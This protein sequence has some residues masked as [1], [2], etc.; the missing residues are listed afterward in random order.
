MYNV[1]YFSVNFQC[2]DFL[3]VC[4]FLQERTTTIR[5]QCNHYSIAIQILIH[6]WCLN[7][8]LAVQRF[9]LGHWCATTKSEMTT[10]AGYWTQIFQSQ[11]KDSNY[12]T[13]TNEQVQPIEDLKALSTSGAKIKTIPEQLF[14]S[15]RFR[16][17]TRPDIFRH[18]I[19]KQ[20]HL[21]WFFIDCG[22]AMDK[23]FFQRVGVSVFF[24]TEL[25]QSYY[26]FLLILRSDR[27]R[28]LA[29]SYMY[30]ETRLWWVSLPG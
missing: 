8:P 9:K 3:V 1:V 23:E 5:E 10:S 12:L 24:M 2:S 22:L 28:L 29:Q 16:P 25:T 19:D 6:K 14:H 18:I 4:P 27:I 30:N 26:C 11:I 15:D 17:V 13:L 20:L 7:S 21:L